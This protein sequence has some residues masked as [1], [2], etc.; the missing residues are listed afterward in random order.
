MEDNLQNI[1]NE[2][3]NQGSLS[4]NKTLVM[5]RVTV[6]FFLLLSFSL[7]FLLV[8][9]S[10]DHFEGLCSWHTSMFGTEVICPPPLFLLALLANFYFRIL[11]MVFSFGLWF[12]VPLIIFIGWLYFKSVKSFDLELT[13]L[14]PLNTS[15]YFNTS[16]LKRVTFY[17]YF[18][19]IS[20]FILFLILAS[21]SMIMS[22]V[23]H[24]S[25]IN[26]QQ[27]AVTLRTGQREKEIMIASGNKDVCENSDLFFVYDERRYH[28]EII[29]PNGLYNGIGTARLSRENYDDGIPEFGQIRST[30][31]V[32]SEEVVDFSSQRDFSFNGDSFFYYFDDGDKLD[33]RVFVLRNPNDFFVNKGLLFSTYDKEFE[34][35]I[36]FDISSLDMVK[37]EKCLSVIFKKQTY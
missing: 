19:V 7:L 2:Q 11:P 4:L 29:L 1:S 21:L 36:N 24:K 31:H 3:V 37:E 28:G 16:R 8:F 30:K 14:P 25:E 27:K 26:T 6:W 23:T 20:P 15:G 35:T 10:V 34:H 12:M 32:D 33:L 22:K 9:V 13:T 17:K 18:L 5:S